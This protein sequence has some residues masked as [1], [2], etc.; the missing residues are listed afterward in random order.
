[1]LVSRGMIGSRLFGDMLAKLSWDLLV[2]NEEY[3]LTGKYVW[4]V[5]LLLIGIVIVL[6]LV[7]G[8]RRAK[9]EVGDVDVAI[10]APIVIVTSIDEFG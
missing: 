4:R 8:R 6:V 3:T 1:M 7:I 10:A 2:P 9:Q 5:I